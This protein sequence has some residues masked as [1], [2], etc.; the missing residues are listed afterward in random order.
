VRGRVHSARDV[1]GSGDS[2]EIDVSAVT[3]L[4]LAT[5][6]VVCE[7]SAVKEHAGLPTDASVIGALVVTG[8]LASAVAF[9]V[10]TWAQQ[11]LPPSRVAVIWDR[12]GVRRAVRPGGGGTSSGRCSSASWSPAARGHGVA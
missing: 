4:R 1:P 12:D 6:A 2:R 3:L 9:A 7:A 5:V 10:Q 11:K 8:V